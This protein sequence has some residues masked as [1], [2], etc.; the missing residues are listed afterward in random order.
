MNDT[1]RKA[2]EQE[3]EEKS[4]RL[5]EM[6][7]RMPEMEAAY[8]RYEAASRAS[9]MATLYD[10]LKDEKEE[11]ARMQ[12]HVAKAREER[13]AAEKTGSKTRIAAAREAV[14]SEELAL[15]HAQALLEK[16]QARYAAEMPRQG[17]DSES[18]WQAAF[19]TKPAFMNLE[20][21]IQPFRREYAEL[22]A[23][24]QEIEALLGDA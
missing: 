22:L 19:L 21:K 10:L 16:A 15:S 6:M 2:L 7:A 13:E 14:E 9:M 8:A 17:F 4:A 3:F 18:A 11:L 20:G 5:T 1:E 24:C 23:R 12:H